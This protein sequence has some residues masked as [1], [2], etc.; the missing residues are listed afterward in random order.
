MSHQDTINWKRIFSPSSI[1]FTLLGVLSAIVALEGFMIPNHFIDGGVTGISILL[2]KAL[3]V[4]I[5]LLLIALNIPFILIGY[6]RI[7]KS[8]AIHTC[9][10]I[11]LLVIGLN[12]L[13]IPMITSDKILI[14]LFGGFFIGLGIGFVIK[15]GGVLD[16]L[17]I[18]GVYTNK[19]S[20]LSTSE[21]V[22]YINSAVILAAAYQFGVE[23]GMYS[24]L[25]YFTAMKISDYVV[26]GF[27][28]YTALTVLSQKDEA[29]KSIIVNDF[30]KAI[31][32]F[33][34]ERGYLPGSF[35]VKYDCDIIMTIVTR[36][37]LHRIK[38]AILNEDPN[39]FVYI[40]SI[41]EVKGGVIKQKV[42][43]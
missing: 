29:I 32:V 37:E 12:T 19:K 8:F 15:G 43:H 39:A 1:I 34:G 16:G 23:A 11:I 5:R 6:H 2:S 22:M 27:E 21:I 24:I 9:I 4:D 30:N 14:A 25:T 28:E 3:D 41:K 40:T 7:G 42:K 10:A 13:S 33:K 38:K 36:L 35:D 20:A 26:D 17:E 18:I 31:S